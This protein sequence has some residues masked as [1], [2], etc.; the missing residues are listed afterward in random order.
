MG[1]QG[2][3]KRSSEAAALFVLVVLGVPVVVA[4]GWGRL[5]WPARGARGAATPR[6][7][8]P[9][10]RPLDSQEQSYL[11]RSLFDAM[12]ALDHEQPLPQARDVPAGCRQEGFPLFVTLYGADRGSLRARA[13][14]GALAE[15]TRAAARRL[16][17]D[18]ACVAR[19]L[20]LTGKARVR[21]DIVVGQQFLPTADREQFASLK[22]SA[23]F[24]VALEN[25]G[26]ETVFLPS[27]AASEG[28]DHLE[29]LRTLDRNAALFPGAWRGRKYRVSLLRTWSFANAAP[30]STDCVPIVRGLP[31]VGA[32]D[33]A[34]V[35]RG[36]VLAADYLL[37]SQYEDGRFPAGHNAE[38]GV[39][40][41]GTL[42]EQATAAAALA[43]CC[44]QNTPT[45]ERALRGCR[46]AIGSL[47]K[48][49]RVPRTRHEAA[50]MAPDE[51]KDAS[52]LDA[53]VSLRAFCAYGTG[54]EDNT[55]D[56]LIKRLA[57]F[58][59]MLQSESGA[60]SSGYD[61]QAERVLPV[62]ESPA[63]AYAQVEAARAL[64]LA[65]GR[66][67]EPR[68]VVG[69]QKA[70]DQLAAD[71]QALRSYNVAD[72]LAVAAQESSMSLPAQKY[73]QAVRRA[74]AEARKVQL[75]AEAA[76]APDL[77]GGSLRS[78]PPTIADTACDLQAFAAGWLIEDSPAGAEEAKAGALSAGRYVLQFQFVPENSYYLPMPEVAL[79]GFRSKPGSNMMTL[80]STTAALDGLNL[81]AHALSPEA[82]TKNDSQGKP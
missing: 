63:S 16:L 26:A 46:L 66:T 10:F 55:W 77:A 42:S 51:G 40:G 12:T 5:P 76:P 75:S 9:A 69:A 3:K 44:A 78:Q 80:R 49:A 29:M 2:A 23:P 72:Q 70:L 73:L 11:A 28:G 15:S 61:V 67:H 17:D 27:D 60:F 37:R 20:H 1:E 18:P 48:Q 62:A 4:L 54:F 38:S 65:Y 79:G 19:G 34:Q 47:V 33:L 59:L 57:S 14:S 21:F 32:V 82:R 58:V 81:L 8:K 43:A 35:Q 13:Q 31:L 30:G 41:V 71:E 36:A 25:E 68:F 22:M 74:V 39:S 64:A 24:G 50:F 7:Q 53:A 56:D 52:L 45:D 6:A